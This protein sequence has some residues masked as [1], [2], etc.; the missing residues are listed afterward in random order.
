MLLKRD[1]VGSGRPR[2]R[3]FQHLDLMEAQKLCQGQAERMHTASSKG[4]LAAGSTDVSL[5]LDETRN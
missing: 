3:T 4:R 5:P 1:D 2:Q